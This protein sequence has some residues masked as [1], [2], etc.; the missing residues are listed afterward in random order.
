M[1][2]SISHCNNWLRGPTLIHHFVS[3]TFADHVHVDEREA[4]LTELDGL[5]MQFP[6]MKDW[7]RGRNISKR[8]T[9]FEH[10]F[11][12][13]FDTE[14]QLVAFLDSEI[15]DQFVRERFRPNV[16]RRAIVSFECEPTAS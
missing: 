2:D 16:E 13:D 6:A 7:R 3:F 14:E 9:T 10:A 15:H 11:V 8:D 1:R 12:V 5:P 4:I